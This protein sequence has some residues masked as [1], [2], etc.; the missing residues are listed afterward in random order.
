[1]LQSLTEFHR[2]LWFHYVTYISKCQ[3]ANKKFFFHF[4]KFTKLV[5]KI[6]SK[7]GFDLQLL[8][9][10]ALY[11]SIKNNFTKLKKL[12]SYLILVN[13]V[14]LLCVYVWMRARDFFF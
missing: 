8:Y 7:T 5:I 3:Q 2:R 1:M 9:L 6:D 11:G 4:S 13:F 12:S 14:W 10:Y